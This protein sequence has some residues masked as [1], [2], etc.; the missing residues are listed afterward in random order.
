MTTDIVLNTYSELSS[1]ADAF[2][3]SGMFADTKS[4][5]QAIV[6]II[7]GREL[8][9]GP[10]YSISRIN[11]IQGKLGLAAETLGA[12]VKRSGK[13]NYT[14]KE[15]TE[16]KCVIEFTENNKPVYISTF[17]MDDAKKA[18]LI[19]PGGGWEKYPRAMLFSRAISQGARIV[20]P[21]VIGGAYTTEELQ[22]IPAV[23]ESAPELKI[24]VEPPKTQP[25]R[26]TAL[27]QEQMTKPM[28]GHIEPHPEVTE[29]PAKATPEQVDILIPMLS[30]AVAKIK[31]HGWNVHKLVDLTSTQAQQLIDELS[32]KPMGNPEQ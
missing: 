1:I 31:S 21:D 20:A 4:Q 7:A 17:T 32:Q 6:K 14:I 5:A 30:K 15:H 8:G 9:L 19:K 13:Y 22:S 10:F 16:E 28:E 2:V 23:E 12:L 3:K 18:N 11:M 27:Q 29:A 25:K 24:E 26:L